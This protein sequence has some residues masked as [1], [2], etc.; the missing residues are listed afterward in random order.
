MKYLKELSG[1]FQL[2]G[3]TDVMKTLSKYKEVM[4]GPLSCEKKGKPS[5]T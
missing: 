1:Y 3:E 5:C 2:L 4:Q